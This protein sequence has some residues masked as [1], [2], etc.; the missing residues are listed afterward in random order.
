M[1]KII[2]ILITFSFAFIFVYETFIHVQGASDNKK[3]SLIKT[4]ENQGIKSAVVKRRLSSRHRVQ[5]WKQTKNNDNNKSILGI[6]WDK[7]KSGL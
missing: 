1:R 7:I 2:Y 6:I 5:I 3:V 4:N